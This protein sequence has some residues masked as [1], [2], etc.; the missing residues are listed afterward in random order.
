MSLLD[1]DL[2]IQGEVFATCSNVSCSNVFVFIA[3]GGTN[4]AAF[5]VYHAGAFLF[6]LFH[7]LFWNTT[8][9]HNAQLLAIKTS[10]VP[11]RATARPGPGS[12][13][14]FALVPGSDVDLVVKRAC[15]TRPGPYS[16]GSAIVADASSID[17]CRVILL[18]LRRLLMRLSGTWLALLGHL[19]R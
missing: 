17:R 5:T 10:H 2:L 7:R 12:F 8:R 19:G 15:T 14:N 4:A 6:S 18:G 3:L 11:R 16:A 13:A 1:G 9:F